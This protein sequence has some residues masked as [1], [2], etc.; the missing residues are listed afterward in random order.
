T[1]TITYQ[2]GGANKD[3]TFDGQVMDIWNGNSVQGVT[4]IEKVGFGTQTFTKASSFTGGTTITEGTLK[5]SGD[6]TLGSGAIVNNA[7]LEFA[8]DTKQT[9]GNAIS[10]TGTINKTGSGELVLNNGSGFTGEVNVT[11][12]TLTL[13]KTG[14]TGTFP[15]ESVITVEG[16]TAVL[17]GSGTVLGYGSTSVSR[18]NLNNGGSINATSGHITL[19]CVMYLNDGK[20]TITNPDDQGDS[21]G[22]FIIDN[23]IHV[24]GGTANV[25]D[26]NRVSIR[27]D[28]HTESGGL[29]DVAD[30]AMLTVNAVIFDSQIAAN[31][32]P[33]VVKTGNGDLVFT[34]ANTYSKDT[35]VEAGTLK[36]IENG[37]LGAGVVTV[38]PSSDDVTATLEFAHDSDQTISNYISGTGTLNKTG[39]GELVLN[40]ASGFK[41]EV[42]V[43]NGTLT[44]TK[45]G[46]TGTFAKESVVTVEGSTA[47]LSGSGTVLGYGSSSVSELHLNDGGS[48]NVTTGHITMGGVMYLND[49]KFTITNP[50][51]QG[52]SYG[53]YI[54][55]NGI[56]VT[57]GTTNSIDANKI[58]IRN[59][60]HTENGG[61]FDVAQDA[62]LTVNAVIFDSI[63]ADNKRPN[64][65]KK[66]EGVLVFTAAN[67]YSKDTIIEAGTLKLTENGSIGAGALTIMDGAI[68]DIS[69]LSGDSMAFGSLTMNGNATLKLTFTKSGND[70]TVSSPFDVGA[71]TLD[72][73]I[74]LVLAG[75]EVTLDD[76][77]ILG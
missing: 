45:T 41:G 57:G 9:F 34:A 27:N 2:L 70:W 20:F 18:L 35:I 17:S 52:D 40:D 4:A 19:G 72:G 25:I 22:S 53:S 46:A 32:R 68:V 6:G 21:Y 3:A 51:D 47:V 8:H 67:T 56:H 59:D 12:G 16:S 49:G 44:I 69:E 63:F 37:A 64:V 14:A 54:I 60:G 15:K 31:R 75:D 71:A 42:N 29:F 61:L 11:G 28:D 74:D 23:G 1:G 73:N 65:I 38:T 30:G 76:V 7:V 66:G 39:T 50:D 24:T 62:V 48:I 36:L 58:S 13:T 26:V 55:D 43:T 10:G 5:L 33:N 77:G